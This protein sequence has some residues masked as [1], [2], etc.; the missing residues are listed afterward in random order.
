MSRAKKEYPL[1]RSVVD[2]ELSILSNKLGKNFRLSNLAKE[3][4]VS[5]KKIY[6][7]FSAPVTKAMGDRFIK[8]FK[9]YDIDLSLEY[10]CGKTPYKNA[11]AFEK[12][13]INLIRLAQIT[14]FSTLGYKFHIGAIAKISKKQFALLTRQEKWLFRYEICTGWE[15][16]LDNIDSCKADDILL[17]P[18]R[19]VNLDNYKLGLDNYSLEFKKTLI[20]CEYVVSYLDIDNYAYDV[21]QNEKY[22]YTF[23]EFQKM[24]DDLKID[25]DK[26]LNKN[27]YLA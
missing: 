17:L 8:F 14:F 2:Y 15:N 18:V 3:I 10:L 23:S 12:S 5:P 4:G 9:S 22:W 13:E 20:E 6:S 24:V 11:L 25:F 21:S 7:C 26:I 27:G 1:Q 19:E 16:L